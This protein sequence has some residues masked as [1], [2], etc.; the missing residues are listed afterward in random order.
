MVKFLNLIGYNTD[1]MHC[2][3][4]VIY[5]PTEMSKIKVMVSRV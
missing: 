2:Y 5:G 4:C 3:L 1:E